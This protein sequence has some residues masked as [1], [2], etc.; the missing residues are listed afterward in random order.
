[1]ETNA[2]N[3][4]NLEPW[5]TLAERRISFYLGAK[6]LVQRWRKLIE[7]NYKILQI[8]QNENIFVQVTGINDG[9]QIFEKKIYLFEQQISLHFN[10]GVLGQLIRSEEVKTLPISLFSEYDVAG[11]YQFTKTDNAPNLISHNAPIIIILFDLGKSI[12]FV[13][14]G[15]HRITAKRY[16]KSTNIEVVFT[17]CIA[18]AVSLTNNFE[19][20]IYSFITMISLIGNKNVDDAIIK[21]YDN[22]LYNYCTK[23]N[24]TPSQ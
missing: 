24:T 16:A 22:V 5:F 18:P 2:V 11:H 23:K 3:I 4:K 8:E 15:N 7:H 10:I 14:D 19:R 17:D 1:M 12:G 9:Y 13:A 21:K 6:K 20:S